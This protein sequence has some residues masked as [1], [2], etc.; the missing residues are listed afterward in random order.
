MTGNV[1]APW[2]DGQIAIMLLIMHGKQ[3]YILHDKSL[4]F[5]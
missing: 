2:V 3:I 1:L 5:K 4:T